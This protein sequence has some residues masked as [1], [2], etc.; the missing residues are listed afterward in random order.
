MDLDNKIF[1]KPKSIFSEIN[2]VQTSFSNMV[3]M[4]KEFKPFIPI[5]ILQKVISFFYLNSNFLKCFIFH[6]FSKKIQHIDMVRRTSSYNRKGNTS[7]QVAPLA[8]SIA[9]TVSK[10]SGNSVKQ[11]LDHQVS[12]TT[13][14]AST[15]ASRVSKT[16]SAEGLFSLGLES[17][18]L[19]IIH[20]SITNI[21]AGRILFIYLF[22]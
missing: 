7:T 3:K 8:S 1:K 21:L 4:L 6:N 15:E 2:K 10:S 14:G 5:F 12:K 19:T 11:S 17:N 9:R 13:M 20:C 22:V 16:D 18:F